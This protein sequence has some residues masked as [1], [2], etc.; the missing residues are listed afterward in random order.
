MAALRDPRGPCLESPRR[1]SS[2]SAA[3]VA[4]IFGCISGMVAVRR[5][6]SACWPSPANPRRASAR[7]RFR[8]RSRYPRPHARPW[9]ASARWS[10]WIEYT[11]ALASGADSGLLGSAIQRL[12]DNSRSRLRVA[13][14]PILEWWRVKCQ[15]VVQRGQCRSPEGCGKRR[16]DGRSYCGKHHRLYG[17]VKPQSTGQVMVLSAAAT[18]SAGR[19]RRDWTCLAKRSIA[20]VTKT[21]A[22][23]RT[24]QTM[25]ANRVLDEV[26]GHEGV[27]SAVFRQRPAARTIIKAASRVEV[28][29]QMARNEDEAEATGKVF[30]AWRP[31]SQVPAGVFRSTLFACLMPAAR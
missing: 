18:A 13:T 11:V 30:W 15:P 6:P 21:D 22:G 2:L 9:P 1:A 31:G 10:H 28:E 23:E 14:G 16:L 3:R 20:D 26:R 29:R 7:P 19:W 12:G 17:A 4:S 8:D 25:A 24:R 5:G 27:R